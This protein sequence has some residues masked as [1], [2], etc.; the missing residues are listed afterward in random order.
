MMHFLSLRMDAH[1]QQEIRDY[2]T[3]MFALIQPIVPIAA[4]AFMDYQLGDLH[5]TRLEVEAIKSGEALK[6][7][8]K[9]ENAEWLEK[10]EK[11]GL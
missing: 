7:E 9:R 8:N 11:L 10:K 2:A 5:L 3:A 1:A 4:E 6:S